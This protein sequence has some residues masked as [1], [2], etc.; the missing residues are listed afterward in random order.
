LAVIIGDVGLGKTL[1]LRLILDN[2]A[3]QD[4]Y[5][6]AFLTVESHGISPLTSP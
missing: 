5:K 2:L 1:C 3:Q 4:N 6:V